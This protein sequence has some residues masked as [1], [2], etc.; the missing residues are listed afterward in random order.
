MQFLVKAGDSISFLKREHILTT[1][2]ML[3][4]R[5]HPKHL[6][7]LMEVTGVRHGCAGKKTPLPLLVPDLAESPSLNAEQFSKYRTAVGILLYVQ[8]EVP[9]CQFAIKALSQNLGNPTQ[10]CWSMLRH[11]VR[12][13]AST[14]GWALSM[15][16]VEQGVGVRAQCPGRDVIE[17]FTDADWAGCRSSRKSTSAMALFVN[18]VFLMSA[19]RSQK[20][21][22]L[23]SCESEYTATVGGT[24]DMLYVGAALEFLTESQPS[25]HLF[26]DSSSARQLAQRRGCGKIRHLQLKLL[27]LQAKLAEDAFKLHPVPTKENLSD[28]MTKSLRAERI[29]YLLYHFGM[30]DTQNGNDLIGIDQVRFEDDR[31]ALRIAIRAVRQASR[32]PQRLANV[33]RVL[34][35]VAMV[36]STSALSLPTPEEA[37]VATFACGLAAILAMLLCMR[38]GLL[39]GPMSIVCLMSLASLTLCGCDL[40]EEDQQGFRLGWVISVEVDWCSQGFLPGF[41]LSVA[42]GMIGL[43]AA[44]VSLRVNGIYAEAQPSC[45]NE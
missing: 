30:V 19:S 32:D 27:W 4:I 23:S 36:E 35:L 8:A 37:T 15:Q 1:D 14:S 28:L 40:A 42:I 33:L 7:R 18:S 43:I 3:I 12:H 45:L 29:A 13:M 2:R 31:Q 22:A 39:R 34:S 5:S 38:V 16:R 26:C 20:A 6:E 25:L 17:C 11:L 24:A 10:A 44:L 21:L 41:I 9:H